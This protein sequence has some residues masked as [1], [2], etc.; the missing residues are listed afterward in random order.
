VPDPG[1]PAMMLPSQLAPQQVAAMNDAL[2]PF[3]E[4]GMQIASGSMPV[5]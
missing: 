5:V 2:K 3:V 1:A 4:L